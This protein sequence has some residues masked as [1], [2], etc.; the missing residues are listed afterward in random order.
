[1][2][3]TESRLRRIIREAIR[4]RWKDPYPTRGRNKEQ[5]QLWVI[6][7]DWTKHSDPKKHYY[8][9]AVYAEHFGTKAEA[10]YQAKQSSKEIGAP[11]WVEEG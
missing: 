2:R 9:E 6:V 5:K 3:I 4:N 8:G 10:E 7:C 1:M 11:M